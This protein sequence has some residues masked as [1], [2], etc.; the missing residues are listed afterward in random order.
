MLL[1]VMPDLENSF[2]QQFV[3]LTERLK[4]ERKHDLFLSNV[5]EIKK[6]ELIRFIATFDK[7]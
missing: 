5:M 7:K 4:I 3:E 6:S 2:G 1:G